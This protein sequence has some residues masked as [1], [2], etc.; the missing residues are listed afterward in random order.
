MSSAHISRQ[1]NWL[2]AGLALAFLLVSSLPSTAQAISSQ[3][4]IAVFNAERAANGIPAGITENPTWSADCAAHNN[5]EQ[6]NQVM[7]HYRSEE[8]RVGKECRSR[9][10]PYHYKNK[11]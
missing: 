6:I 11:M 8:R 2:G 9:W 10:S 7:Q 5:Y 4:A 1:K 3:Q